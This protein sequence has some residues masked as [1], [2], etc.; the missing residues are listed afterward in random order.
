MIYDR[1][2]LPDDIK[3][4][5]DAD[6]EP[7]HQED[8]K[9]E[10]FKTKPVGFFKDAMIRLSKNR[11]SM[12][13]GAIILLI[14][15]MAIMVPNIT[16]YSYTEQNVA[17]QNLPPKIP[18]LEKLGIFDGSRVLTDRRKDKLD[19]TDRYPEGCIIEIFNEHDVKNVTMCDVK[20]DYYKYS[21]VADGEYHWL[22][23]DYLGR[24][25]LTR[26]FRGARISLIIAAVSVAVNLVIG[27][28][29]G[30][31]SGYCGGKIDIFLTHLAEVLDGMPYVVVTILFMLVFGAGMFSIILAMTVTGWIGTSRLIRAQF[32]RFKGRE[33]VLAA[34][35]MG[36][37]D[38]TLIFRHILP[39]CV[40]PLIIRAMI[41]VPGAIFSEA[42]L[43]YIGL[44]I[45]PPEPSIGILLS[46]GQSVLLQYPYQVIFPAV[47]I[48]LLMVAFN[49]FANGL[50]DALD[51]THRARALRSAW[52]RNDSLL[53]G[54]AIPLNAPWWIIPQPAP[55][56]NKKYRGGLHLPA[57]CALK[58]CPYIFIIFFC[59]HAVLICILKAL[60]GKVIHFKDVAVFP[61][62]C[63]ERHAAAQI[64][65]RR[66]AIA[67]VAQ[68]AYD[69]K[70]YQNADYLLFSL[71]ILNVLFLDNAKLNH[72]LRKAL[73]HAEKA[74]C[75][76]RHGRGDKKSEQR[77]QRL[78]YKYSNTYI[79]SHYAS[80]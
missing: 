79:V 63:H 30:A 19:D 56:C 16:G 61:K 8:I 10:K 47:L 2:N 60:H 74:Y 51:P 18:G 14:V 49:L 7:L 5:P 76:K 15:L 75:V 43:A 55:L 4:L 13:S 6:F 78:K 24:D 59:V 53:R 3:N 58:M 40:G 9:D 42:F 70:R 64:S 67:R 17:Q 69:H 62:A 36:V 50:R 68:R 57:F 38:K 33:Y 45:A 48:S 1:N 26:L 54:R 66:R 32:Y 41:A 25:L 11:V 20:V 46:N 65:H 77:K 80:P 72:L 31:I 27:V 12:I 28:V 35:T 44:G 29:Y 34:R 71:H 52:V 23:T 37:P 21:G 39:N 73:L 22:G